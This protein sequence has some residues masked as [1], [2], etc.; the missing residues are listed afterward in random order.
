MAEPHSKHGQYYHD[1]I[2][3]FA[4]G[5]TVPFAL[6]AGL[7]SLGS[8]KLVVI[9]GLAEL[10]SGAVSMGLGSY[11]AAVTELQ[12]YENE[13][14]R[15]VDEVEKYPEKEMDEVY[16][17]LCGYGPTREQAKPYVSALCTRKSQWIEFMMDF[18]LKLEKP[19]RREAYI[20]AIVMGFAYLLGGILP[21]IPYFIAKKASTALFVSIGITAVILVVFGFYKA[22]FLGSTFRQSASSAIKT[23]II[24]AV[25]AGASYG[26]VRAIDGSKSV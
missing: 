9:G 1:F 21:M 5:L 20:C 26:I 11:L 25:A 8:T 3:G 23:L 6:T 10:F 14:S 24:G 15:E 18:E 13:R 17:I 16:D 22:R 7:S 2:L 19:K 4:D 12:R